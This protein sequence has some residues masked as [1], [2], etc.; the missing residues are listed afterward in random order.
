[1]VK[2]SHHN[3]SIIGLLETSR[4]NNHTDGGIDMGQLTEWHNPHGGRKWKLV[5]KGIESETDGVDR[6]HGPPITMRTL[7]EDFGEHIDHACWEMNVPV[8]VVAAMIPIEAARTSDGHYDPE[9]IR[10]EP[11]YVSDE[12]TP[13]R[14]SPGLMQTLISTARDMAEK[15][16]LYDPSEVDRKML[17]EPSHSLMLGTAY[18]AHQIE[19]YGR[20]PVLLCA[21]YN[22]GSVR[23]TD[24]NPWRL[25]VYGATRLD[26]YV[27]WFNDFRAAVRDGSIQPEGNLTEPS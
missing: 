4:L 11:G 20:D 21:A 22:A 24:R 19:R 5:P 15:Y 9:S 2:S 16:D 10:E 18:L 14:V 26:R 1:M 3:L 25:R 7:W 17:F 8:D 6:T 12:E 13:H 23:D 27:R